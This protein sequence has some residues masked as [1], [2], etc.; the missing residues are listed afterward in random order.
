MYLGDL[1]QGSIF[2]IEGESREYRVLACE[3]FQPRQTWGLMNPT[4]LKDEVYA[5]GIE[6]P[7][8][9]YLFHPEQYVVVIQSP[10]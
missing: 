8:G 3:N 2:K 4:V 5:I 1:S 7:E 10:A 9:L 6:Y